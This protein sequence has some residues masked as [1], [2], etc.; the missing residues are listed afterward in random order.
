M[1]ARLLCHNGSQKEVNPE[2]MS[3]KV[4]TY[5]QLA[6][7]MPELVTLGTLAEPQ[8]LQKFMDS[9]SDFQLN[10]GLRFVQLFRGGAFDVGL[11][12]I[13]EEWANED[14]LFSSEETIWEI[15]IDSENVSEVANETLEEWYK[16]RD[17]VIN[18]SESDILEDL[19]ARKKIMN[20]GTV[21][22]DVVELLNDMLNKELMDSIKKHTFEELETPIEETPF[23]PIEE[24]PKETFAERMARLKKEKKEKTTKPTTKTTTT[25][26]K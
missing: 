9:I 19:N 4:L 10:E 18:P 3:Y 13:F 15:P 22:V 12:V 16:V 8:N 26:K 1:P 6:E 23:F 20:D 25:K 17:E 21:G 7:K 2:N 24:T 14:N 11:K 5:A